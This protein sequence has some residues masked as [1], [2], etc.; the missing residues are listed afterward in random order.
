RAHNTVRSGYDL[1]AV[2]VRGWKLRFVFGLTIIVALLINSTGAQ[3]GATLGMIKNAAL[4]VRPPVDNQNH[5]Y[6]LDGW[7][8]VHPVGASPALS[9]STPSP[10]KDIAYSLP[11]LPDGPGRYLMTGWR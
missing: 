1:R 8:G 4:G 9:S 2:P 7:G 10:T 11:V 5:L 3:D 6:V